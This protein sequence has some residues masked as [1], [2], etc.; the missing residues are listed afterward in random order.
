MGIR[1]QYPLHLQPRSTSDVRPRCV[2]YDRTHPK[3]YQFQLDAVSQWDTVPHWDS[4]PL[5]ILCRCGIPC[6]RGIPCR[7]GYHDCLFDSYVVVTTA[8]ERLLDGYADDS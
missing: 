7:V 2:N 8:V 3:G 4:V 5:R 1:W 6:C